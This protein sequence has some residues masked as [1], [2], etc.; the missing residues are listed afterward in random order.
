[1]ENVYE[2]LVGINE[3]LKPVPRLATSWKQLSPTRY[4][5]NIRKG[6]KFS[7]GR[8]MTVADVVG[9]LKRLADPKTE[10][11]WATFVG[12]MKHISAVGS[13]K[14]EVTLGKPNVG[15]IPALGG[16]SAAILPMKELESGSFDPEKELLGT[17][18][19]M[20]DS[21]SQGENWELSR[22]PYYWREGLPKADKLIVRIIPEDAARV[23]GLRDGTLDVANF[24]N[25]DAPELL[26]GQSGITSGQVATTDFYL[27]EVNSK[28]SIFK[29]PKAREAL[30][31]L[32]D[33]SEITEVGM[34]GTGEPSAAVPPSFGICDASTL[35]NAEPDP[36]RAKQL[37]QEAGLE[38]ETVTLLASNAY[39]PLVQIAQV[40]QPALEEAGLKVKIEQPNQGEWIERV[41]SGKAEFD[42]DIGF[43]GSY[44]DPTMGL[45][46][47]QADQSWHSAWDFP[48]PE[49]DKL[50]ETSKTGATASERETAIKAACKQI[51]EDSFLIPLVTKPMFAAFR[52]DKVTGEI[53]Q[54]IA[55][56]NPLPNLAEFSVNAE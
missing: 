18:P 29:D 43:D 37:I 26:S 16:V 41:Y 9:S 17:G 33:R 4:V 8:E 14:V 38:G 52:D 23:A 12:E 27:L 28:T 34:A 24:D 47:W 19:F 40:L 48:D 20:V 6:V 7:N 39:S 22:N 25:P 49:L 5:F 45:T 35:P 42:L 21:H 53:P 15:F 55:F 2:G 10:A 54:Q 1:L 36:E 46:W 44:A 50:I 31:M 3:E 56:G 32:I 30:Q 11:L 51:G 13:W